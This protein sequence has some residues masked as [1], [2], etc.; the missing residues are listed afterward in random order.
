MASSSSNLF[1]SQLQ[2]QQQPASAQQQEKPALTEPIKPCLIPYAYLEV[3]CELMVD[4]ENLQARNF[5]IKTNMLVQGWANYFDRL[6]GPVYPDLVKDFWSHATLTP[7]TIISFVL[8]KEI[9]ITENLIRKLLNLQG[10]G[11]VTGA[12]P[13]RIDWETVY[14]KIFTSGKGSPNTKDLKTSYRVWAKIILG[15]INHRKSTV[16][17]TYIN[18]DQQFLLY[19]IG[20]GMRV[21]L[22]HIMFHHLRTHVKESREAERLKYPKIKKNTIPMGR[23]ISDILNESGLIDVLKEA[24][25]VKDLITVSG[26]TLTAHTLRRMQLIGKV[27]SPP[28]VVNYILVRR[29]PVVDFQLFL[30][31][32]LLDSVL[33][34]LE[35]CVRDKSE[36]DPAWF[37]GRILPTLDEL[38]KRDK[39]KIEKK[40]RKTVGKGPATKKAKKQKKPSGITIS[41]SVHINSSK[42]VSTVDPLSQNP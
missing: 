33:F 14:P 38:I 6:I 11:G 8:G 28:T 41:D 34:Y 40:K 18:Q 17:T 22:P 32:E 31:E 4:F 19:C 5:N 16:S 42:Q 27:L 12:I 20:K 15:T 21:D 1:A 29:I 36:F 26:S 30:K 2:Q 39:K 10:L 23:L 9:S 13:G 7:N 35:S 24:G 3:L 25:S 37:R